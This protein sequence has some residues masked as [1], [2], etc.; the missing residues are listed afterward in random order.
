MFYRP[1]P[2]EITKDG[3]YRRSVDIGAP[4]RENVWDSTW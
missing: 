4:N 3:A 2:I 1:I